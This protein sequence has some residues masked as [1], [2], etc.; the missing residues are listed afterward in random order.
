MFS[1]K[2]RENVSDTHLLQILS[3][4]SFLLNIRKSLNIQFYLSA[5]FFRSEN[6]PGVKVSLVYCS[7]PHFIAVI[8]HCLLSFCMLLRILKNIFWLFSY[9]HQKLE[10]ISLKQLVCHY[11]ENVFKWYFYFYLFSLSW[12]CSGRVSLNS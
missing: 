10:E 1:L 2:I 8:S 7:L 6:A 5:A 4:D 3:F 9:N 12:L 11:K